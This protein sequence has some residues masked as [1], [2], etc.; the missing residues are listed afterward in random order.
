MFVDEVSGESGGEVVSALGSPSTEARLAV[1]GNTVDVGA[2]LEAAN[3]Y[4]GAGH[5]DI[6]YLGP[7]PSL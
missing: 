4:T 2:F 3:G 6:F 7:L 1:S 5:E